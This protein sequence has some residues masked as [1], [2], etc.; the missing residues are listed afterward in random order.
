MSTSRTNIG[1]NTQWCPTLSEQRAF[2]TRGATSR[3]VSIVW[4]A[5]PSNYV[6]DGF[7]GL[8][9]QTTYHY[10][11]RDIGLDVENC[12]SSSKNWDNPILIILFRRTVKPGN[13]TNRCFIPF[14]EELIFQGN[15]NAVKRTNGFSRLLEVLIEAISL[16]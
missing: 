5:S 13:K 11:G 3:T 2:A 15:G 16:D 1:S 12:T 7:D 6:V 14:N 9:K 4:I 10:T 8:D